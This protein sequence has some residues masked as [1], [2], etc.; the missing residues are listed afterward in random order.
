[1]SEQ[2]TTENLV[3]VKSAQPMGVCDAE[4]PAGAVVRWMG[5]KGQIELCGHHNHEGGAE[6][7]AQG[8]VVSATA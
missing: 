5:P 8:F 6:L 3:E 4:C 7:T 1:M 2:A